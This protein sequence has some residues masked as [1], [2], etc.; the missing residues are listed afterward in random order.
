MPDV[1]ATSTDPSIIG[2][3]IGKAGHGGP[4]AWPSLGWVRRSG[5]SAR[6]DDPRG[7]LAQFTVL[8]CAMEIEA[9]FAELLTSFRPAHRWVRRGLERTIPLPPGDPD[10]HDPEGQPGIARRGF[11]PLDFLAK[12]RIAA[13]HIAGRARLLDLRADATAAAL[14]AHPDLRPLLREIDRTNL[15]SADFL[16]NDRR[17]TQAVARWAYDHEF[18]GLAYTSSFSFSRHPTCWAL[19]PRVRLFEAHPPELISPDDPFLRTIADQFGL[20]IPPG[21]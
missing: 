12:R 4:L 13:F 8:Y 18:D 1:H 14:G 5:G 3:R 7:E 10:N 6:F 20:H 15:E 16:G 19:F 21:S 17:I 9:C 2:Y 11:V